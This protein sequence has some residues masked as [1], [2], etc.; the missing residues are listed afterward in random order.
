MI[1]YLSLCESFKVGEFDNLS[2]VWRKTIQR[3]A[4]PFVCQKIRDSI[5]LVGGTVVF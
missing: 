4:N 5:E 1:G 3:F 2:L